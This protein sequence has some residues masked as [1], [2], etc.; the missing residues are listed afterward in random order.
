[1]SALFATA[2]TRLN[3]AVVSRLS[4]NEVITVGGSVV[5]AIFDNGNT[6]GNVGALGMACTQP[7]L[8]LVSSD[9]PTNPVGTAV[10]VGAVPY[11]IATHE[12]DGTGIS[13][14]LLE[15]V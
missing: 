12:P 8:T 1:M 11:L 15:R 10:L 13:R 6:L 14:L 4:T 9:V 2:L 3:R 5:S 7:L